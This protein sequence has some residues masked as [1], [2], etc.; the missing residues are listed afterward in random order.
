[1]AI[2]YLHENRILH[3]DIKPQNIF[4]K[5]NGQVFYLMI[6]VHIL[7]QVKIGDLGIAKQLDYTKEFT[8]TALG[9]IFKLIK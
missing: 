4:L 7:Y 2:D 9:K 1:M 5:K 6:S 3:R 8:K